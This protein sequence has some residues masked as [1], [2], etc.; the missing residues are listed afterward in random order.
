MK[1]GRKKRLT[2][3][4]QYENYISLIREDN[5][6]PKNVKLKDGAKTYDY[7][8]KLSVQSCSVKF[9]AKKKSYTRE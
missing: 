7:V 9:Q 5:I 4:L 2:E 3:S 1:T 8:T 6:I